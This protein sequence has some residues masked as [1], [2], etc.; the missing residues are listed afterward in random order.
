MQIE[1]VDDPALI[2]R[3]G[4]S[5][6]FGIRS[7][8]LHVSEIYK[9]LMT[10]LDPKTYGQPINDDARQRMEI[11]I[12]FENVLERGL[13]EKY[14]TMRPGEIVTPEGVILS[15]DGV[16]PEL[17]AGEE[18]KATF[19]SCRKGI[20][21]EYG[22]PLPTFVV[23]FVQ[24]KAYAKWLELL[25]WLLRVLFICGDYNRPIQPQFHSYKIKFTQ[26]EVDE[27]WTMLMNLAHDE[28]ML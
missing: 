10:R 7:E 27:N 11:G 9:R 16:N 20:V 19:K 24:M 17:I 5:A 26:D 6:T 12:V 18:Y 21:D 3:L 28:G 15:P 25:D 2:E 4:Q 1:L 13:A 22:M 8:G 14:G 23:W